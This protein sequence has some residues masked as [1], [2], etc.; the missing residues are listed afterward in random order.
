[1]I[2]ID[3]GWYR[4]IQVDLG[5]F[6]LIGVDSGLFWLILV[7]SGWFRLI[8]VDSGWLGLL[9]VDTGRYGLILVDSGWFGLIRVKFFDSMFSLECDKMTALWPNDS[10]TFTFY[11][12]ISKI[13]P[14]WTI[15]VKQNS[16]NCC[17]VQNVTKWL[18]CDQM[19]AKYLLF[20][21]H[22]QIV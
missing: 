8:R 15:F 14:N 21:P 3:T 22:F 18:L 20:K 9:R 5:W 11:V 7:D 4:L 1:M 13:I 12:I 6:W 2:P 16:L 17:L 10:L 19:I